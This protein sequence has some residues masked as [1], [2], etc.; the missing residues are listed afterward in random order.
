MILGWLLVAALVGAAI[1]VLS[2]STVRS[3]I[4][5]H[6]EK[7]SDIVKLVREKQASGKVKVV[8]GVFSK[9]NIFRRESLRDSNAW[10]C[11]E[12]D[13]ELQSVFGGRQEVTVTV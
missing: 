2:W 9:G 13:P 12:L 5:G 6:K 11:E 4:L 8:A 10:E 1:A 7:P 3:W